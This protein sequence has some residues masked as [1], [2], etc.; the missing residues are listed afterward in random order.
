[1]FIRSH[2]ISLITINNKVFLTDVG[3]GANNFVTPLCLQQEDDVISAIGDESSR[4]IRVTLDDNEDQFQKTWIVQHKVD[5]ANAWRNCYSFT[6]L[7]FRPEDFEVMNLSTSTSPRRFF[8]H[9]PFCT[10]MIID[11]GE[12][13][14][15]LT[16]GKDMKRQL[17]GQT[18]VL[19]VFKSE[20]DRLNALEEHFSIKIGRSDAEAIIGTLAEIK[21]SV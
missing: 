11:N 20:K 10:K 21:G 2:H 6:E 4:L 14:G 1:M 15:R 9:R 3:Y 7:E 19:I 8:T 18:E 17:S 5:P 12:L 13:V 16:C